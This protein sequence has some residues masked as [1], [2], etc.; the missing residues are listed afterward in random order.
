MYHIITVEEDV[1]RR[2]VK[3]A[4]CRIKHMTLHAAIVVLQ[5][6]LPWVIYFWRESHGKMGTF[7][8][9]LKDL[10]YLFPPR[11]RVTLSFRYT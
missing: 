10:R 11:C 6:S 2:L 1:T 9:I 5:G 7:S 8:G 4:P 3:L